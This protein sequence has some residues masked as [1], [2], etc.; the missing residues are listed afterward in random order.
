EWPDVRVVVMSSGEE[1]EGAH[2]AGCD[3]YLQKPFDLDDFYELV[4]FWS[5]DQ[6]RLSRRPS[7]PPARQDET[8]DFRRGVA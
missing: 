6:Y 4:C 3:D 5:S 7:R 1:R 2:R 8:G